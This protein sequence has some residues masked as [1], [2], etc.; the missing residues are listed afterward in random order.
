MSFKNDGNQIIIDF[1]GSIDKLIR[2]NISTLS[3][4]DL[5]KLYFDL[6]MNLK[7]FRGYSGGFTGFGEYILFRA[8]IHTIDGAF[9][10]E[11]EEE[12]NNE[13]KRYSFYRDNLELSQGKRFKLKEPY[14]RA[15]M[16]PQLS[17]EPDIALRKNCEFRLLISIKTNAELGIL[18]KEVKFIKHILSTE[19][20]SKAILI[21]IDDTTYSDNVKNELTKE[22]DDRFKHFVLRGNH[23]VFK[24]SISPFLP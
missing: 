16:K 22:E 1:L 17:F 14:P 3:F 15:K 11:N 24:N 4:N 8:L 23:D 21:I 6:F 18:L 10:R 19:V 9:R 2:E 13:L 7:K 12:E 20:K 5:G